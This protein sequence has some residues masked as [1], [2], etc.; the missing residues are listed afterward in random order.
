[1][2]YL[3]IS[4]FSTGFREIPI[5]IDTKID[6]FQRH[7]D[8]YIFLAKLAKRWQ[9]VLAIFKQTFELREPKRTVQRRA[10][11]RSRGELSNA[12]FI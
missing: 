2:K 8:N 3:T 5:T 6:D 11:C 1:M 7:F 4:I 12:N 10:F 9:I